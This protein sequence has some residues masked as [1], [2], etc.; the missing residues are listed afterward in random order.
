MSNDSSAVQLRGST[1]LL[2]IAQQVA[3]AY[4]TA[5]PTKKIVISAGGTARGYK[6]IL[7]ST[8]D[9]AMV[10]GIVP[11]DLADIMER[12]DIKITKVIVA[13][14]A[15]VAVVHHSNSVDDLSVNQ[16]KNIFSG[17]I[18]NWKDVGG[19]DA[20]INVFIGLPSGGITDTWKHLILGENETYTPAGIAMTSMDRLQ[21]IL[22]EPN[23]ITYITVRT[24]AN[25]QVKILKV[26]G[27][28]VNDQSVND[29]RYVLRVPLSLAIA[30]NP[31]ITIRNFIDFFVQSQ[32][33]LGLN[34]KI[35]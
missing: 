23:S 29:G 28:S 6:A 14:D 33:I 7:D 21:K 5:N 32:N 35:T 16:L 2:P 22:D 11:D 13:Y 9:I 15:I 25:Y 10:S 3:E 4:M 31:S 18:T 19:I 1:T 17:R 24:L 30:D 26:D 8:A 12:S 27:V 34:E 20:N